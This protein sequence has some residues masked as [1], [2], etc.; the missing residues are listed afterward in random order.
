MLG[1]E[2]QFLQKLESTLTGEA[3]KSQQGQ[4]AGPIFLGKE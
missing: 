1:I 4:F 3:K 2:S